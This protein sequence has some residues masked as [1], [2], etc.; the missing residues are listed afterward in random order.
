M[1]VPAGRVVREVPG[2][3]Y[4]VCLSPSKAFN[5][6]G[7]Q[8]AFLVCPDDDLRRRI[9]RAINLN[10]TCDVNLFG[11]EAVIA[12]YTEGGEWLDE[13][14]SYIYDNYL[15]ARQVLQAQCQLPVADLQGTYLLWVDCNSL[16]QRLQIDSEELVRRL[17]IDAKVWFAAGSAYGQA[18]EGF[19]RIN[20][21]CSHA[22]LTEALSRF[23]N[24]MLQSC[25]K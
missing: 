3:R 6:A 19:L 7:L 16:C 24:F 20:L 4:V 21:A 15:Y 8:N 25:T 13:L 14:R 10:E 5:I 18:G 9:D 17:I 23:Q 1:Y 22:T 2:L 11:V 12:A